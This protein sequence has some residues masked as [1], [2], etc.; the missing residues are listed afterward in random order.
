MADPITWTIG[1]GLAASTVKGVGDAIGGIRQAGAEVEAGQREIN[2]T[3]RQGAVEQARSEYDAA[4]LRRSAKTDRA[5]AQR[6]AIEKMRE[7]KLTQ[8]SQIARAAMYGGGSDIS[9]LNL[10]GRTSADTAT[11]TGYELYAGENMALAKED[12]ASNRIYEGLLAR[13][14]A[15]TRARSI[16]AETIANRNAS[17]I[18][19]GTGLFGAIGTTAL[20]AGLYFDGKKG[21]R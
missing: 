5:L 4:Q 17:L 19:A 8:S 15:H 16:K 12:S 21:P 11:A 10:L 6:R 1:V 13:E 18:G 20:S 9:I 3:I 2:A 14:S 7:G